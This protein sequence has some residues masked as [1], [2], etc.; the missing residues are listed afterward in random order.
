MKIYSVKIFNDEKCFWPVY[1]VRVQ[2]DT[3]KEAIELAKERLHIP[4]EKPVLA[5]YFIIEY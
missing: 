3:S 5:K 2:C 4:K 1:G